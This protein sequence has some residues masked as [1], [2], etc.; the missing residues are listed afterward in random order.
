MFDFSKNIDKKVLLT[1]KQKKVLIIGR[2]DTPTDYLKDFLI[3]TCF[4]VILLK[5]RPDDNNSIPLISTDK[6]HKTKLISSKLI[7]KINFMKTNNIY[8]GKI[9]LLL[10]YFFV[11]LYLMYIYKLKGAFDIVIGIGPFNGWLASLYSLYN[12]NAKTVYYVEDNIDYLK[13]G[14]LDS[15][16][17]WCDK[18]AMKRCFKIW[19][20]TRN[21]LQLYEKC[22]LIEKSIFV[23]QPIKKKQKEN[24][25][26]K[27]R[28]MV[29]MGAVTKLQGVDMVYE[30]FKKIA[31]SYK[32][33]QLVIIGDGDYLNELKRF[34]KRDNIYN[35]IIFTGF[36][37]D[38]EKILT[39]LSDCYI[40]LALYN[41]SIYKNLQYGQSSKISMYLGCGLPTIITGE[42]E[43]MPSLAFE[44]KKYK[45]GYVLPYSK[46]EIYKYVKLLYE[47]KKLYDILTANT[48][49]ILEEYNIDYI[50]ANAL[51]AF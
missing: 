29:F 47:D 42:G 39:I 43:N 48:N 22:K 36:I 10:S 24:I 25:V 11:M 13:N 28:K 23:P 50:F 14:I 2:F 34:S 32:D 46:D 15:L 27:D 9:M 21:H 49:R 17:K 8:L 41:P 45:M 20:M 38:R 12:K 31:F 1:F 4:Q 44:V 6:Y 7:Y 37:I 3:K 40:G 26:K 18:T 33:A 5:I 51:M 19:F 16:I 30:I 35:K